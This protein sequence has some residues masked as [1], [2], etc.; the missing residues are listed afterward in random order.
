M[1]CAKLLFSRPA[2]RKRLVANGHPLQSFRSN[3]CGYFSA[4]VCQE[5]LADRSFHHIVTDDLRPLA[6]ALNDQL[7]LNA[8]RA[9]P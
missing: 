8:Y 3:L 5:L 7:V 9:S 6:F 4:F 2:T 1:N